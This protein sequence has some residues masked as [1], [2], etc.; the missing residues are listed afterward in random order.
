MELSNEQLEWIFENHTREASEVTIAK[1][2]EQHRR[3]EN[4]VLTQVMHLV[5][6]AFYGEIGAQVEEIYLSMRAV[7]RRG[8]SDTGEDPTFFYIPKD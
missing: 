2:T 8:S 3:S 7:A 5:N 6:E 1:R 4:E